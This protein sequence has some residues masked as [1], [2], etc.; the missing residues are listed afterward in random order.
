MNKH[1]KIET[2]GVQTDKAQAAQNPDELR[3]ANSALASF[4]YDQ[5]SQ[6]ALSPQELTTWFDLRFASWQTPVTLRDRDGQVVGEKKFSDVSADE[7]IAHGQ[8]LLKLMRD[9]A[10]LSFMDY[11]SQ[12]PELLEIVEQGGH[13]TNGLALSDTVK[14]YQANVAKLGGAAE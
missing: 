1:E 11:F 9:S 14:K 10:G 4:A 8:G 5:L 12:Q 3:S 7:K 13:L 6:L 2:D